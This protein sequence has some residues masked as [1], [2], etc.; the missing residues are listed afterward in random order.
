MVSTI[1][2]IIENNSR[3]KQHFKNPKQFCGQY[4]LEYMC[5]ILAKNIQLYG[6]WSF[7]KF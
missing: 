6:G 7:P 1:F 2:L 5:K 3:S 4:L